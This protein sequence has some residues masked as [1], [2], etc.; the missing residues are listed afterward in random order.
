MKDVSLGRTTDAVLGSTIPVAFPAG[1]GSS[2]GG[3]VLL[4][5]IDFVT[6]VAASFEKSAPA[7]GEKIADG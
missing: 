5:D 4:S 3:T 1:A 7:L 2:T 6:P